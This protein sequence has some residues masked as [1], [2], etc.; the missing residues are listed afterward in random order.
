MRPRHTWTHTYFIQNCMK[1]KSL[2]H[3]HNRVATS[4]CLHE[5][6]LSS[7]HNL[8]AQLRNRIRNKL[9][10]AVV[11][12]VPRELCTTVQKRGFTKADLHLAQ[13]TDSAS[14]C[15]DSL[16]SRHA[17][18]GLAQNGVQL[19]R[20]LAS[21]GVEHLS[22]LVN[23]SLLGWSIGGDGGRRTGSE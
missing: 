20:M 19:F 1:P 8:Q 22:F 15:G 13:R 3:Q 18:A 14:K 12:F 10:I 9:D 21:G 23:F 7:P 6:I 4:S 5:K 16:A 2:I 17:D 11:E